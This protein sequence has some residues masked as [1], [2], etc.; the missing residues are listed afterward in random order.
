MSSVAGI[1]AVMLLFTDIS[2]EERIHLFLQGL[3]VIIQGAL[4]VIIVLGLWYKIESIFKKR[5]ERR[6]ENLKNLCVE[7]LTFREWKD[8]ETLKQE[9]ELALG[10]RVRDEEL[11]SALTRL[12]LEGTVTRA[13]SR[14]HAYKRTSLIKM[15]LREKK[16]PRLARRWPTF[17]R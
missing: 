11:F 12:V 3:G 2:R 17:K 16:A 1:L 14:R 10:S 5:K 4:M 15:Y 7:L 13:M 6:K 8:V 9:V